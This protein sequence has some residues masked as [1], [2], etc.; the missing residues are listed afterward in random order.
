MIRAEKILINYL[1][2]KW[3]EVDVDEGL[4]WLHT[5]HPDFSNLSPFEFDRK[6]GGKKFKGILKKLSDF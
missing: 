5:L 2:G 1:M 4:T 3:P 6:F